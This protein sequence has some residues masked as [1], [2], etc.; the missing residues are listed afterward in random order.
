M[1]AEGEADLSQADQRALRSVMREASRLQRRGAIAEVA[2]AY[3]LALLI[4]RDNQQGIEF[5]TDLGT[6]D[7]VVAELTDVPGLPPIPDPN[8]NSGSSA[9]MVSLDG[10]RVVVVASADNPAL[11]ELLEN[12]GADHN[13]V[14]SSTRFGGDLLTA[15]DDDRMTCSFSTTPTPGL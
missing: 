9:A 6:L 14:L 15:V 7:S 4:D 13:T 1:Y 5:F 10:L 12:A 2:D 8:G 11:S 3:R